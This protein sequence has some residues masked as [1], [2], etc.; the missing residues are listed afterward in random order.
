MIKLS[1]S[2]FTKE[3]FIYVH[4]E[5]SYARCYLKTYGNFNRDLNYRFFSCEDVKKMMLAKDFYFGGD[6]LSI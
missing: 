2:K 6:Q 5:K 4:K 1:I 3:I